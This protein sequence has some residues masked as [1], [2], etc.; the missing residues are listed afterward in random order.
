M[1]QFGLYFGNIQSIVEYTYSIE[2]AYLCIFKSLSNGLRCYNASN[3]MS[4]T[5]R[6]T[7][8]DNVRYNSCVKNMRAAIPLII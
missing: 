8:C 6:F 4:V 5:H 7:D 3:G 1:E 2:V